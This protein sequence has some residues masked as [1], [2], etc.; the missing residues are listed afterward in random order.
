MEECWWCSRIASGICGQL[1]GSCDVLVHS[2]HHRCVVNL[3]QI[4]RAP[5]NGRTRTV[6]EAAD[7]GELVK[8]RRRDLV[9]GRGSL[10]S[11]PQTG[12]SLNTF[13]T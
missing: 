2:D 4:M 5:K 13:F 3:E 6:D 12:E 8:R 10:P 11:V 1:A 7:D 9:A